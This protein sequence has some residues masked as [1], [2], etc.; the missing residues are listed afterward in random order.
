MKKVGVLWDIKIDGRTTYVRQKGTDNWFVLTDHAV[1]ESLR[2]RGNFEESKKIGKSSSFDGR[3]RPLRMAKMA[4]EDNVPW[5][6][7]SENLGIPEKW[8]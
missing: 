3:E 6:D 1:Y 8:R 2:Q 7:A 5:K 4:I